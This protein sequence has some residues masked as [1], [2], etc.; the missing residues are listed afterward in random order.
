MP[1]DDHA[2]HTRDV[3][4]R[5]WLA[6][7]RASQRRLLDLIATIDDS[8]ARRPSLLPAWTVGHLVTH[9]ARGAEGATRVLRGVRDRTAA[10]FYPHGAPGRA[11][12]IEAG[13][14]RPAAE[15]L[16]DVTAAFGRLEE[17]M[18]ELGPRDWRVGLG[19]GP[20]GLVTMPELIMHRWR[21]VEVH[22]VDL[23][24]ADVGGPT[25][26]ELGVDYIEAEWDFTLLGLG[27]RV[28]DG[29]TLV[30]APGDR[31]TRGFGH[32]TA[33][34]L[35]EEPIGVT[36]RYLTGRGGSPSWPELAPWA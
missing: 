3:T 34:T 26:D 20:F 11:A 1:I 25:W 27:Q 8:T 13:S 10:V 35:I 6:G 36:L 16:A 19:S 15:L 14:S 31:P 28:P 21:E 30:L 33:V 23:G 5:V 7:A 9:L 2:R 18:A 29:R 12:D 17:A 4:P 22:S 32:G 24:L